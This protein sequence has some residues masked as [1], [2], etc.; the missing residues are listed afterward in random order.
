MAATRR[1]LLT[2]KLQAG[3]HIDLQ[4]AG[5]QIPRREMCVGRRHTNVA[6]ARAYVAY[7][8]HDPDIPCVTEYPGLVRFPNSE[9]FLAFYKVARIQTNI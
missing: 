5:T 9:V 7:M 6:H 8:W 4:Q 1:C 2:E 3:D